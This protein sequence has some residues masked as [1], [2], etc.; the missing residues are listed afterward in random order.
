MDLL[1]ES[2]TRRPHVH[3]RKLVRG[4]RL[5]L[6]L[7]HTATPDTIRLLHLPVDRRRRDAGQAGSYAYPSGRP[8][9]AGHANYEHAVGCCVGLNLNFFTER[10]ATKV[11]N[12]LTVQTLL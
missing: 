4:E 1:R 12:R 6:K 10:H 5:D 2:R 3:P 11:I 7:I 9:A 8:H